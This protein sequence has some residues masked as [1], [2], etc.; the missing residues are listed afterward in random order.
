VITSLA[1]PPGWSTDEFAAACRALGYEVAFASRYLRRRGWVQ[2][3]T[4][5][6]A[7]QDALRPLFAGLARRLA[8]GSRSR[9]LDPVG[10]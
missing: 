10:A 1:T 2:I 6:E 8:D 4:M 3:A 5:G 9:D 7:A